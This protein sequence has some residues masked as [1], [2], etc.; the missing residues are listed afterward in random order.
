MPHDL[1]AKDAMFDRAG[2]DLSMIQQ[3]IGPTASVLAA[4]RKAG[5]PI[6]Y[7]KMSFRPALSDLGPADPPNR[8]RHLR[9]GVGETIQA[10]DGT[11]SP[12]LIRDTWNTDMLLELAPQANN[13]VLDKLRFSGFYPTD[14][15]AILKQLGV[16]FFIVTGCTTSICV[17]STVREAMFRDDTCVVLDD[18]TDEP[19]GHGLPRN[20]HG[21]SLLVR[22]TLFGWVAGSEAFIKAI[23]GPPIAAVPESRSRLSPMCPSTGGCTFRLP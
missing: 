4:A 23:A 19:I 11:E 8:L 3:A 6:I 13:V 14:L 10:P 16:T 21:A 22:Q 18:C 1:G 12:M 17:E 7:V 5:V 9:F 2:I 15:D 20:N